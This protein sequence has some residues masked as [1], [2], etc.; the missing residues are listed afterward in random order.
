MKK[1][2]LEKIKR[3]VNLLNKELFYSI[4]FG[5]SSDTFSITAW[6]YDVAKTV[7]FNIKA[8]EKCQ[9]IGLKNAII[10]AL[11]DE[12]EEY[13]T[14]RKRSEIENKIY[15]F[16]YDNGME[17]DDCWYDVESGILNITDRYDEV[18]EIDL[19]NEM[20][21]IEDIVE[22]SRFELPYLHLEDDECMYFIYKNSN[23]KTECQVSF[24]EEVCDEDT[25]EEFGKDEYIKEL[26]QLV[27][28]QS[29]LIK[30]LREKVNC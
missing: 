25:E 7:R 2:L 29:A 26:E 28:K 4:N 9:E 30:L 21:I 19:N 15:D 23:G 27:A 13:S 10:R 11:F 20:L 1:E 5:Y 18:F 3:V 24:L 17:G 16:I 14:E 22:N 8:L 12:A 6:D